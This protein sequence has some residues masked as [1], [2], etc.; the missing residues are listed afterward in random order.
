MLSFLF[1]VFCILKLVIS[2]ELECKYNNGN[3]SFN[4][5]TQFKSEKI[6]FSDHIGYNSDSS[7]IIYGQRISN[8]QIHI[9]IDN[10]GKKCECDVYNSY[11]NQIGFSG[12][13]PYCCP[14]F[15]Y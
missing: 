14:N 13:N 11:G 4:C 3:N 7:Y 8:N 10:N 12:F 5:S 1:F 6:N 9:Y 2:L 15:D